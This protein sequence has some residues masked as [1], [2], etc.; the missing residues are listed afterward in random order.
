[1]I[2]G[3]LV[4]GHI[5]FISFRISFAFS[6]DFLFHCLIN[7][8]VKCMVKYHIKKLNDFNTVETLYIMKKLI[9]K[10]NNLLLAKLEK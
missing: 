4:L 1:M 10:V 5:L 9:K 7:V 6:S 2:S 3:D 8:R